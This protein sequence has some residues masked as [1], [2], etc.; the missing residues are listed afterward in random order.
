MKIS[1]AK[2][3]SG[4]ALTTHL[5]LFDGPYPVI[6][7]CHGFCGIREMLLPAY[8]QSFVQSGFAVVS[9]DYRGFGDSDG[10]RGRLVPAMQI[11][12]ITS[13]IRWVREQPQFDPQRIALWGTSLGGGHVFGAAAKDPL[14]KCVVSQ[15]A[16]ADGDQ[17]VTGKMDDNERTAFIHTL[18]AMQEKQQ[19]TGRE[20]FVSIPKVLNDIESKAF[21][22][23]H[24]QRFPKLDIKIPF[25]T[26]LETLRYKPAL[27]A[28]EVTCPTLVIVAGK[29]SV[30]P[31]EYGR[32][33][34]KR[35]AAERKHFHEEKE[36]RHYDVY[37]GDVFKR[38]AKLQV[39]WFRK[40]L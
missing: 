5:P 36:A 27:Y 4:V 14:I 8:A 37:S 20:L 15:L 6:I 38:L 32:A 16:F 30:N 24:R 28:A 10:E 33:L 34:F 35:V 17:V 12:D 23:E 7:L 9:F 3:A 29:D 25:L 11:A 19:E 40:Y 31:P 26:V 39:E 21:F 13:V 2:I 1:T 18:D 22:E